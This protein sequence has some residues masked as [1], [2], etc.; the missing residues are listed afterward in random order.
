M[1]LRTSITKLSSFVSK[2]KF[3][4]LILCIGI[5]LMLLPAQS[6]TGMDKSM[7]EENEASCSD[8]QDDLE[9]ILCKVSGAGRVKV[10]L[11]EET[12]EE[13]EYQTNNDHTESDANRSNRFDTV[14]ISDASK[15][16]RGLTKNVNA[17]IYRGA[18]IVCDGAQDPA[19]RL[20]IVDAV[21]KVTGLSTNNISVLK[22]E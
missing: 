14:I 22:M 3:V 11:T 12:S 5:I 1:E 13:T 21:S 19:V 15:S 16:E 20:A 9:L 6:Q 8:L 7:E 10:F 2:Y 17:P 4:L 18:L